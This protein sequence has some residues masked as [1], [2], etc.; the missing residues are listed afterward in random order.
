MYLADKIDQI[1]T[2]LDSGHNIQSLDTQVTLLSRVLWD[3]FWLITPEDVD[4]IVGK[5]VAYHVPC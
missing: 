1:Q 4:R 2:D 5:C 3:E